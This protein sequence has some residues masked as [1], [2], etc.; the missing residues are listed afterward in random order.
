MCYTREL[1]CVECQV[2][3][4]RYKTTTCN[5][6]NCIE[7]KKKVYLKY[8]LCNICVE[9]PE[10]QNAKRASLDDLQFYAKFNRR[11]RTTKGR[12]DSL[13]RRRRDKK[14][15]GLTDAQVGFTFN[16][17]DYD[18]NVGFVPAKQASKQA[19]IDQFT[20]FIAVRSRVRLD[21]VV[22]TSLVG[23]M[24]RQTGKSADRKRPRQEAKSHRESYND[25]AALGCR[26]TFEKSKTI[27]LGLVQS[28]RGTTVDANQ[29]KR[30]VTV[31]TLS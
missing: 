11:A 23:R 1:L 24:G 7:R 20:V 10:M 13:S 8:G 9:L 4:A 5:E 12:A 14:R 28:D 31:F 26:R 18:T 2:S 21:D 22:K 16:V 15:E 17:D 29:S 27:E 3:S 19:R 30:T 6:G 25:S